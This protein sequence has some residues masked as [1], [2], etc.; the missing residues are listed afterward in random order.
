MADELLVK[1][2]QVSSGGVRGISVRQ[3]LVTKHERLLRL[4]ETAREWKLELIEEQIRRLQCSG[5]EF[6]KRQIEV[7]FSGDHVAADTFF[8]GTLKGVGS[9]AGGY[10]SFGPGAVHIDRRCLARQGSGRPACAAS[11]GAHYTAAAGACQRQ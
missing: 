8:V 3:G 11:K 5:P 9:A 7:R 1:G 2:V 10:P 6:W 4:E